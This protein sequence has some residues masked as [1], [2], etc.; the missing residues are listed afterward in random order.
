MLWRNRRQE[1]P[2]PI[3]AFGESATPVARRISGSDWLSFGR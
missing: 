2:T 3:G 1:H